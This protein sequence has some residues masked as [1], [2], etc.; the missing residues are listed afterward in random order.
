MSLLTD[1]SKIMFPS[2]FFSCTL[3][4]DC[5]KKRSKRQTHILKSEKTHAML[6]SNVLTYSICRSWLSAVSRW[7]KRG[8]CW[9]EDQEFWSLVGVRDRKP[10]QSIWAKKGFVV[11]VVV[12]H[13]TMKSWGAAQIQSDPET[14]MWWSAL[15]NYCRHTWDARL[16]RAL[17]TAVS[18]AR[19]QS[20]PAISQIHMGRVRKP[21]PNGKKGVNTK[22]QQVSPTDLNGNFLRTRSL[23]IIHFRSSKCL[24]DKHSRKENHK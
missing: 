9:D 1:G 12:F 3:A 21:S 18:A 2:P 10:T 13:L 16:A 11:V 17:R 23:W 8:H 24:L 14:Q 22:W 4:N 5:W 6:I 20:I 15:H 19:D 7:G